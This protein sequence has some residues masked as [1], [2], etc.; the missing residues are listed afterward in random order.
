MK[1]G[2]QSGNCEINGHYKMGDTE[3]KEMYGIK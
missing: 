1:W 3:K 2:E